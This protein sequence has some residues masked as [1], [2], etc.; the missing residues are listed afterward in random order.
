MISSSEPQ[1]RPCVL[2]VDDVE[3]NLIAFE[4]QLAR[5]GF[6]LV[7]ARSGNEALSQLL[8]REFAVVLLDVQMP[9][10]N[11]FEVARYARDDATT[12][13]VPIIFVT[14]MHETEENALEGYGA[15]A[16][17]VLFKPVNAEVLRSKVKVFCELWASKRSL[18]R[19]VTAHQRTSAELEAFNYSVSHDLRAPL[20][21]LVGFS[22]AV[23]DDCGDA[24]TPTAKEYL[25]EIKQSAERMQRLIE[26]LLQLS[27]LGRGEVNRQKLDLASMVRGTFKS[28]RRAEPSR[29]VELVCPE[30]LEAECDAR[31]QYVL[32][33]L[34]RNAWKFSR[35]KPQSRIEVGQVPDRAV[36]TFFVKDDGAGFDA[37]Y[38]SKLFKPFQRLHSDAEFEGTGIGLA[39]VQRIVDRHRGEVWAESVIGR[40]AT[41]YFTLAERPTRPGEGAAR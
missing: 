19:E 38:A 39:I 11:G 28:L 13:E 23:I 34:V 27:R 31:V 12:R 22:Q 41:F 30:V 7:K 26:D 29:Q 10:M 17:D 2:I 35:G 32:D 9:E 4:A 24:L 37:A 25:L 14:A 1:D 36:P 21:P 40:G 15:G 16:V 33:N 5:L 8:K 18:K 6:T 3:A 20:R